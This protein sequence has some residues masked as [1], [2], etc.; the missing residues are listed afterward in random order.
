MFK[1]T[2]SRSKGLFG[3]SFMTLGIIAFAIV[4]AF[5]LFE[6]QTWYP[7]F[8]KDSTFLKMKP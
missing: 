8:L 2:S 3:M 4:Y 7:Q 5:R 6:T 1:S